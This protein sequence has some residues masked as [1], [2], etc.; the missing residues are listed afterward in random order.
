MTK[1]EMSINIVN[2][3]F[4][5]LNTKHDYVDYSACSHNSAACRNYLVTF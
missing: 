4:I 1:M 2:M 5:N 3:R